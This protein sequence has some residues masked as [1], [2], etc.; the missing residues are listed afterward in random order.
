MSTAGNVGGGGGG[1]G[2]T[3]LTLRGQLSHICDRAKW[4]KIICKSHI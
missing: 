2:G 3:V 4:S 1:G